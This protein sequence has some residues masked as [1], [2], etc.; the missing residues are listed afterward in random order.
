MNKLKNVTPRLQR[1]LDLLRKGPAD[2]LTIATRGRTVAP[3][4]NCADL[5]KLGH[6][7]DCKYGGRTKEGGK[8]YVYT[9]LSEPKQTV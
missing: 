6:Q 2:T 5:R 8:I 4:A 7:I 9:L 1:T 3:G